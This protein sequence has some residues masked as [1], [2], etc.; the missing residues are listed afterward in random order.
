ME[1]NLGAITY[2]RKAV[3]TGW[4]RF[5]LHEGASNVDR[6]LAF[7][8]RLVKDAR[9]K[10]FLIIDDLK[11]RHAKK[12]EAWVTSHAHEIELFYLPAYAPGHNPDEYLNQALK[13]ALRQ[14]P[15]P[16]SKDELVSNARSVLRT[17]QRSPERVRAYF[18]AGPVRY[19]ARS[20]RY[21]LGGSVSLSS[22][23]SD[24]RCACRRS[25]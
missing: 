18:A 23:S 24:R 7:L 20:V 6:F 25:R 12:V 21:G 2:E 3:Q 15:Q 22:A 10:V 4:I 5:M 14:P 19:A 16:D 1:P 8:R 9:Q 11:V 13:Q 17:I